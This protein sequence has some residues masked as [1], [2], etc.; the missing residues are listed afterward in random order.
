[1][2]NRII[3]VTDIHGQYDQF[4]KL[5]DAVN[6]DCRTDT[7]V[8]LGDVV[9][10]GTEEGQLKCIDYLLD[11]EEKMGNRFRWLLGNHEYVLTENYRILKKQHALFQMPD[12]KRMI[13]RKIYRRKFPLYVK[14]EDII[15][16]HAGYRTEETDKEFFLL[17]FSVISGRRINYNELVIVGHKTV[18]EP[19]H[20]DERGERHLLKRGKLPE[21]GT[22]FFDTGCV[23]GGKLTALVIEDNCVDIIQV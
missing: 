14:L 22:I 18:D 12:N 16:A 13:A 5:M 23:Y 9:D 4:R 1:M 17:D 15:F 7:L 3:A 6:L 11:I 8:C 21:K 20:V 10:R 19:L 2:G